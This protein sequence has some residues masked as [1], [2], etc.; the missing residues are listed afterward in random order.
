[1]FRDQNLFRLDRRLDGWFGFFPLALRLN[2]RFGFH[3][4]RMAP[5]HPNRFLDPTL[6]GPFPGSERMTALMTRWYFSGRRYV[7]AALR[8]RMRDDARA[9]AELTEGLP[10]LLDLIDVND[11]TGQFRRPSSEEANAFRDALREELKMPVQRRYSGGQD[12]HGACGMLAATTP[13]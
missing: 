8:R 1:M 2:R 10:I 12:I 5:G 13:S 3:A 4:E 7:P 9:L 11:P 6:A